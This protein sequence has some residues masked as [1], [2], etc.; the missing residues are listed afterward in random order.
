MII[1]QTLDV[2]LSERKQVWVNKK[3][4]GKDIKDDK[5]SILKT[6]ADARY[7]PNNWII[8]AIKEARPS[9]TTHPSTFTHSDAKSTAIKFIGANKADGLLRTG[10]V[11]TTQKFDVFG[12][13]ATDGVVWD[14]YLF[15]MTR[16]IDDKL[17]IEHFR[18][19]TQESKNFIGSF[20]LNYGETRKKFLAVFVTPTSVKTSQYLKQVYFPVDDNYHLLSLL[21]PS[22]LLDKL[23]SNIDNMRFGEITKNAKEMRRANSFHQAGY[24]DLFDLTVTAFGGTKPQNISI[25]NSQ[26]GGVAYLLASTPPSLNQRQIRLPTHDF[27]KN[28]L[29]PSQFKESFQTLHSL[30]TVSI[31]NVHIR[32]GISNILKYIIDQV[33]QR[34]FRIRATSKG[35]SDTE[36]YQSLPFAQCIWL[37]DA[38]QLQRENED[39]WVNDIT[40][41]FA[42][43]ILQAYEYSCKE[44]HIKLSDHEL[45]EVRGIVEQAVGSDRE[46]FK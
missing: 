15:L 13:A 25:L 32:E 7:D 19:E 10:N 45:R 35:W 41:S 20:N 29:H 18:E 26:N 21:T 46:F 39:D 34:A 31:N 16:A 1:K 17:V 37:D 6:G 24:D 23:K 3:T 40:R 12:N 4:K 2:F 9:I 43:W 11:E 33:L 14:T 22:S 5:L 44:T 30:I 27:F 28:S 8:K 42:R 36:H 38:H